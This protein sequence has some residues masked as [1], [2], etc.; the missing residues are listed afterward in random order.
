MRCHILLISRLHLLLA[1]MWAV[2]PQ[3]KAQ[4]DAMLTH[5]WAVP[6]YYNP[7]AAGDTDHI[8]LRGGVWA[9]WVGG[10]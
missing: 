3:L 6:T 4:G 2:A 7:A 10:P 8:R 5:Y 9:H 1:V